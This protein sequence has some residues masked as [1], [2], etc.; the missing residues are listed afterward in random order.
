MEIGTTREAYHVTYRKVNR[1]P[2]QVVRG[3]QKQGQINLF[4]LKPRHG[5]TDWPHRCTRPSIKKMAVHIRHSTAVL[6]QISR[7]TTDRL[8]IK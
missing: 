5:Q 1:N 8:K 2:M 6:P 3:A 4:F 7:A